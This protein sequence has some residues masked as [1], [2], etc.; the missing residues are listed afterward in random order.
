[1][2]EINVESIAYVFG[3]L[4][5]AMAFS[6]PISG[7]IIGVIGLVQSNKNKIAK[8]KNLNIIGIILSIIFLVIS[9]LLQVYSGVFSLI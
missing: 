6:F 1:M 4:S 7:L 3:I 8:A 9:I 2:G 5:I